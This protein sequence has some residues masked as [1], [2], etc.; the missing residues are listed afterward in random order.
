MQNNEHAIHADE[1]EEITMEEIPLRE[2]EEGDIILC[3]CVF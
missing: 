2:E 1:L 3:Q